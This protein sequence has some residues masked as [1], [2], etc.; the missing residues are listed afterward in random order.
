MLNGLGMSSIS[1]GGSTG[2]MMMTMIV[3]FVVSFIVATVLF[4][5]VAKMA[6]RPKNAFLNWLREYLNFR[7]IILEGLI[8]YAYIFIAV[9][10]SLYAIVLLFQGSGGLVTGVLLLTLGN[11]GL[12]LLFELTM[13][14]VGIW[15]N[16]SDIESATA[17]LKEKM[18]DEAPAKP[19]A[20]QVVLATATVEPVK[21]EKSEP[22]PAK[23]KAEVEVSQVETVVEMEGKKE[24]GAGEA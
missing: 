12:R 1:F 13:L 16:T 14:M 5:G 7:E 22:K 10:M 15:K 20:P 11:I 4:V 21:T 9:F 2:D 19:E 18:C 8:K 24:D 3:I 17:D 6:K 23:P